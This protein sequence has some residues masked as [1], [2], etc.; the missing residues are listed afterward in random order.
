MRR[1]M[2][3]NHQDQVKAFTLKMIGDYHNGHPLHGCFNEAILFG[4]ELARGA[5]NK[6]LRYDDDKNP[7][8]KYLDDERKGWIRVEE[9]H[10]YGVLQKNTAIDEII[11]SIKQ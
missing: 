3:K 2:N 11:K 7:I 8:P 4:L 6:E 9:G 1:G 5:G 10:R